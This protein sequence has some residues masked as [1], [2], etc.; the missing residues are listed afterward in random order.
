MSSKATP[1]WAATRGLRGLV[2][3]S[4]SRDWLT[5]SVTGFSRKASA[6]WLEKDPYPPATPIAASR[7]LSA[8]W[9]VLMALFWELEQFPV[10]PPPQ[11]SISLYKKAAARQG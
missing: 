4:S 5:S 7:V 8:E 3:R 1:C 11:H 10:P 9:C 6:F 2:T